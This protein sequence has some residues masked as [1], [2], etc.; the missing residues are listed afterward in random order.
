MHATWRPEEDVGVLLFT[1]QAQLMSPGL[2]HPPLPTALRSQVR[3]HAQC[4][5][6]VLG[7]KLRSSR[8]PVELVLFTEPSLYLPDSLYKQGPLV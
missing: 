3:A 8:A 2:Y 1:A 6:W 7:S 5:P 4:F